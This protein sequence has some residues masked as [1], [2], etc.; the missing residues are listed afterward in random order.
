MAVTFAMRFRQ[1]EEGG[2]RGDV[3]D[4]PPVEA[5]GLQHIEIRFAHG[6]GERETLSA[7]SSIAFWRSV[8]SAFR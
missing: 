1:P 3:P 8:M 2:D 4:I 6:L 7:K 5:M